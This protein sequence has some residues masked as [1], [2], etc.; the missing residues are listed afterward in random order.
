M[1]SRTRWTWV[2]VNS[3]SWWWTERPGMLWFMGSQRVG[4]DW[5]TELNWTNINRKLEILGWPK[6]HSGFSVRYYGKARMNF[7]ANWQRHTCMHAKSLSLVRLSATSW[8]VACQAPLF[9]RFSRQEYWS[10]LPCPPPGHLPDPGI[11]PTSLTFPALAGGFFTT[12]TTW[13]ALTI[14]ITYTNS[15]SH[16]IDEKTEAQRG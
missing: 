11:E 10:E 2:W 8:T 6:V 1:A 9:M 13:E 12:S 4:H 14:F 5:A 15:S 16:F 3:G 7:L